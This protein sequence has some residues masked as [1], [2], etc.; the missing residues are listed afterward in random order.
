MPGSLIPLFSSH[1][2]IIIADRS[3]FVYFGSMSV[4]FGP[5]CRKGRGLRLMRLSADIG[6]YYS[7]KVVLGDGMAEIG[8]IG[9]MV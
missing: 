9:I 6:Q 4:Y 8:N 7:E 2:L 1:R 5:V 3:T